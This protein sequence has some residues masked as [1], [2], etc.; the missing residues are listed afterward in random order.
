[1]TRPSALDVIAAWA[2]RRHGPEVAAFA[3]RLVAGVA[4]AS[5]ERAKAL[6]FAAGKLGDFGLALGLGLDEEI[7]LSDSVIERFVSSRHAGTAPTRRTLRTNLRFLAKSALA[8][9]PPGPVP[10]PRERAK[11]PYSA[12]ELA[13]YLALADTQPTALRR[14]R[15]N[16]LLCLGAGAGL[17]GGELRAVRGEDVVQ[18]SGGVLV[19]VAS[20]RARAVPVLRRYHDRLLRAAGFFGPRYLVAGHD[21]TSHNV[22][23]PLLRSLSG[24]IG[25]ARLE[26]SRLRSTYLAAAAEAIGLRAFMDAAGIT[27]SQRLGDVVAGMDPV[28]EDEAVARLGA[29]SAG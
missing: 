24:G 14:A 9:R 23:N 10:L 2:P 19:C 4:P 16:A 17:I 20:R 15:A 28:G 1:M 21:P 11:A 26:P 22:T 5:P 6:L 7:L 8:G 18:R 27:C 12:S 3:R 13:A 25:L 29:T